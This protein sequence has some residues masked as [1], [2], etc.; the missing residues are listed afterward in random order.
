[1]VVLY[2]KPAGSNSLQQNARFDEF[3]DDLNNQGPHEALQ[4]RCPAQL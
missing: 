4:M 3:V 1:L 2:S